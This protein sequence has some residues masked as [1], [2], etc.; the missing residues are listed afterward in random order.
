MIM[1][2]HIIVLISLVSAVKVMTKFFKELK[3][4]LNEECM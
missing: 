1:M 2:E 3:R 4:E